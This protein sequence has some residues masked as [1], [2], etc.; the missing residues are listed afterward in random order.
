MSVV[1]QSKVKLKWRWRKMEAASYG[2][3]EAR[4]VSQGSV[5]RG[6]WVVEEMPH[7]A[8]L[9]MPLGDGSDTEASARDDENCG[10]ADTHVRDRIG[11]IATALVAAAEAAGAQCTDSDA[12]AGPGEE[13]RI[14][15][16]AD[17]ESAA[18]IGA[19]DHEV[20]ECFEGRRRW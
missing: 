12:E 18:V 15:L 11:V 10:A 17:S 13:P 3:Q 19:A 5:S 2:G 14:E 1:R 7:L 9:A 16:E 4:A 6:A 20:P 8:R